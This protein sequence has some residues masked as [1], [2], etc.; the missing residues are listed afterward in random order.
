MENFFATE[1]RIERKIEW[2]LFLARRE[3]PKSNFRSN[4]LY[5]ASPFTKN[6]RCM[7]HYECS[8]WEAIDNHC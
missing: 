5:Q 2:V 4:P 6:T 3:K 8:P 7:H 1:I